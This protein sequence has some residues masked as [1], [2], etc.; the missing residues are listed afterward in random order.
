MKKINIET[1][2]FLSVLMEKLISFI[3]LFIN[4][5]KRSKVNIKFQIFE[6]Y[7]IAREKLLFGQL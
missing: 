5:K 7:L 3:N 1:P 6:L 2:F 4:I